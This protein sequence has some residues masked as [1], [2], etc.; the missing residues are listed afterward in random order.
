MSGRLGYGRLGYF[1]LGSDEAAGG[2]AATYAAVTAAT[3][4]G[5][6]G[7]LSVKIAQTVT[8]AAG[9]GTAG[10][11]SV[12]VG[13][14]ADVTAALGTGTAGSATATIR[15]F[16]AAATGTGTAGDVTTE[17]NPSVF[18]D[19]TAALGTATAGAAT[20]AIAVAVT[21]AEGT[22]TA[23]D[24]TAA[25]GVLT[26]ADAT[27]A[28]GT[29]TAGA[30]GAS[31]AAHPIAATATGTAG[32]IA[33]HAV[34]HPIAAMATGTAGVPAA[35]IGAAPIAA[36][37]FGYA[38]AVTAAGTVYVPAPPEPLV[39]VLDGV[40]ISAI[41]LTGFTFDATLGAVPQ[42]TITVSDADGIVPWPLTK[43]AEFTMG[44]AA[45]PDA[46]IDGQLVRYTRK[47]LFPGMEY[48]FTVEGWQRLLALSPVQPLT[49]AVTSVT[50]PNGVDIT[51]YGAY[52]GQGDGA[53]P[54]DVAVITSAMSAWTGPTLA[55]LDIPYR[56]S[57]PH[58]LRPNGA[59]LS[60]VL[61][62]IAARLNSDDFFWIDGRTFYW[63]P[64]YHGGGPPAVAYLEA[65]RLTDSFVEPGGVVPTSLTDGG[66][67]GG[68]RRGVYAA[69]TIP[70][71]NAS[72]WTGPAYGG[73]DTISVQSD[74]VGIPYLLGLAYMAGKTD[75]QTSMTAE[76]P[77]GSPIPHRGN[78]IGVLYGELV[79]SLAYYVIRAVRGHFVAN[80][81]G[82]DGIEWTLDLGDAERRSYVY[83]QAM[84]EAEV[85][86]G[87]EAV[88][89]VGC[90]VSAISWVGYEARQNVIAY[91]LD[92]DR[93]RLRLRSGTVEWTLWKQTG[94]VGPFADIG[95]GDA[96]SGWWIT[97][98]RTTDIVWNEDQQLGF[99]TC[100]VQTGAEG[101]GPL[102]GDKLF[103][104]A[105]V[106]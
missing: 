43:L 34:A 3:G 62:D 70:A 22:G 98:G 47:P 26:N 42:A 89:A 58:T 63:R 64:G 25:Y 33:A 101:T 65:F 12:V 95:P 66:E 84:R 11:A 97:E 38:I 69:G 60:S 54:T 9:T 21:A 40:D 30:V 44:T 102:P 18:V 75:W 56:H 80:G 16:P 67:G 87:A 19:V 52:I 32:S 49:T 45:D 57:F 20:A 15:A 90:E 55:A 88:Q 72:V 24:A 59:P 104:D 79:P 7:A 6:A 91:P 46:I 8:A 35:G 83:E 41:V 31:V 93:A 1:R 5:T 51:P 105:R 76:L 77:V 103:M 4:T 68:M 82:I 61:D 29:G 85:K 2:A 71:A 99:A 78:I 92:A 74:Q 106:L 94:G 53:A 13:A 48:T 27:P 50:T 17:I 37:G 10:D 73:M 36:I 28:E 23:H 96:G 100:E 39:I 14:R 86:A 81:A